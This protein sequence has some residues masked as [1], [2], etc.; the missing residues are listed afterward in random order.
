MILAAVRTAAAAVVVSLCV[1]ARG[2]ACLALDR[3]LDR[4]ARALLRA[5]PRSASASALRSPASPCASPGASTC[6]PAARLRLQSQQQHRAAR[7]SS[8][9]CGALPAGARP[10]QGRAA[11]AARARLGV[12][13]RGLRAARA[14]QPRSE[15]AGASTGRPRRFG[16]GNSFF[17]FPE[18]TR[19]RTG[20]LLP[21][22]KGGF[23]MAH[24]GPGADRAGRRLRRPRGDAEGQSAHLAGDGHGGVPPGG[25]DGRAR[26]TTIATWSSWSRERSTAASVTDDVGTTISGFRQAVSNVTARQTVASVD[27]SYCN[28][29]ACDANG[30]SPALRATRSP[31]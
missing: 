23:V 9:R 5:R 8:A 12:R 13:R 3:R 25:A 15:L 24:Q 28:L 21:F 1:F 18:G 26:R 27:L 6:S 31:S 7:V 20:E 29:C 11:Q 4:P 2:P 19:S 10:L 30:T 14:R 16:E 22:K 17:I